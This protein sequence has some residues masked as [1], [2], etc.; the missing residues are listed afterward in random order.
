MRFFG[1]YLAANKKILNI[2]VVVHV[3]KC[4]Y[5]AC[6]LSIFESNHVI[7][8]IYAKSLIPLVKHNKLNEK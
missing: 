8:N 7:A 4:L 2:D 6:D 1:C 3:S 5:T